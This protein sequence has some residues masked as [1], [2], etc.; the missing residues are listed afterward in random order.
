MLRQQRD[1]HC[2]SFCTPA[3]KIPA[4]A[5]LKNSAPLFTKRGFLLAGRRGA[6]SDS[7]ANARLPSGHA[8]ARRKR[9][10]EGIAMW[11]KLAFT[12]LAATA[13]VLLLTTNVR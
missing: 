8:P 12:L 11:M 5:E 10:K 6:F 7:M 1:G 4:C 9:I 13:L 2:W 3:P